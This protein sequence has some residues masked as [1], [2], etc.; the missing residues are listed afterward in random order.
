ML[1][2]QPPAVFE[3]AQRML[4]LAMPQ[5]GGSDDERAI[6]DCLGQ[7]FKLLGAAQ[8][9]LRVNSRP[10]F[11]ERNRL[12]IHQPQIP[13]SEIMHGSRRRADIQRIPRSHQDYAQVFKKGQRRYCSRYVYPFRPSS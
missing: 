2:Q 10:R 7:G 4:Q 5:R 12:R 6:G 1:A 9:V 3:R 11:L 8:D 13:E